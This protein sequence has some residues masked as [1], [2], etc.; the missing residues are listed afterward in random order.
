VQALSGGGGRHLFCQHPGGEAHGGTD[1][2]GAGVDVKADGGYVIAPPAVH[3]SGQRYEWE[4]TSGPAVESGRNTWS[5]GKANLKCRSMH[6]AQDRTPL[7]LD[8]RCGPLYPFC[9]WFSPQPCVHRHTRSL[10]LRSIPR[11][12]RMIFQGERTRGEEES[13]L[14]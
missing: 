3:A 8:T 12:S 11:S 6:G 9:N 14:H 4:A 5:N 10:P 2:L 1:I 13:L 7:R